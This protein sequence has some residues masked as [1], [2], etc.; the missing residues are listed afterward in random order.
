[1]T[2]DAIPANSVDD[3][4]EQ[5]VKICVK[6]VAPNASDLTGGVGISRDDVLGICLPQAA[7]SDFSPWTPRDFYGFVHTPTPSDDYLPLPVIDQLQCNLYP[8]QQRA[9]K[10]LLRRE[11]VGGSKEDSHPCSDLPHGFVQTVDADGKSCLA[12]KFLGLLTTDN[13]LPFRIGNDLKGGLLAE[14]MGLGKTVELISLICL[15]KCDESQTHAV[16]TE[17][18]QSSATLIVTPPAILEQWINELHTLA[19]NL[20]VFNY[21]GLRAEAG[22]SNH[23][24]LLTKCISHDIVLTTYNILAKEIHY[25]E[26]TNRSLR[27]EKRYQKRQSPLIQTLWWRVVLDEAQMVESG[28]SNAAK[29]AKLIPRQF[30]WAVSGTPVKKDA[31]DLFGLLDFLRFE[32]YC[33]LSVQQQNRLVKHHK[34]IFRQIFRDLTLRHTKDQI[35]DEIQLPPQRRVVINVPFT[36]IEEQH[37]STLFKEM[38]EDCGLDVDGA[39][40]TDDW[41]PESL[42]VIDK[43]RT[44][45]VRLRQT[46]LHPEVGA[47]NRR[48]LGNGK[49]PLRTVGEVLEVMI[50]Q[51][52]TASRA[53]ERAVM[54]SEIRRGQILEHADLSQEALQIWLMTLEEAKIVVQGCREQLKAEIEKLGL[55]EDLLNEGEEDEVAGVNISQTGPHRLRLRSALEVEHMST[56]FVANGYYQIKSDVN[57][58]KPESDDYNELERKE[59][60]LYEKAKALRIELLLEARRKADA[61]I[62]K[63]NA[64]VRSQSI[65]ALPPMPALE[66]KAGIETRAYVE[67]LNDLMTAMQRQDKQFTEWREETVKLLL[68]PLVDEEETDLNGDEYETS[69]KQQDE[70]YVYVDALRALVADRHDII[71]GQK[72][73][74][75]RVETSQALQKARFGMGHS[76]DLQ[77]QLITTRNK[78]LPHDDLGS[79]RGLT[80]EVRELKMGLRGAVERN[81]SRAAA[82]LII[83]N[84]VFQKLHKIS[85]EQS[86]VRHRLKY[87][88]ICI[89]TTSTL[90][91]SCNFIISRILMV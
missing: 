47:K 49:G 79:I 40:L 84:G 13:A 58:T 5:A 73:E 66:N 24:E 29:V 37:Y 42:A 30:A 78:L 44:W 36:Q 65:L 63:L 87:I 25:A 67:R 16:P 27:H 45:L 48:A 89:A 50:E 38:S 75:I 77:I 35:K 28:V 14:E 12:S 2:H 8:F 26:E 43:M 52:D 54:L 4:N 61:L 6:I 80:A 72:N 51:N 86:K 83:L 53:E 10:W 57:Q 71:T 41:N 46:C 1:M 15:H 33:R 64:K 68:M 31:R 23:R 55:T 74:L 69:T 7:S 56:F 22:K 20:G 90:I 59:E 3:S 88:N 39:P 62:N 76:P 32:P 91:T 70:V 17:L 85:N 60:D 19:P 34:D 9:V 21:G 11:G 82:E 18:Q 81:N